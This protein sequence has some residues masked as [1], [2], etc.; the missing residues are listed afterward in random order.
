M[1]LSKLTFRYLLTLSL[2]VLYIYIYVCVCVLSQSTHLLYRTVLLQSL[3]L[4]RNGR[5]VPLFTSRICEYNEQNPMTHFMRVC[6]N[7]SICVQCSAVQCSFL[8]VC[9]YICVYVCAILFIDL[10]FFFLSH[11]K[12]QCLYVFCVHL[13]QYMS[14][15]SANHFL[16]FYSLGFSFILSGLNFLFFL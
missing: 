10:V 11:D 16:F 3:F 6:I 1:Y 8:Y 2:F 15:N 9:T 14:I 4:Y 5:S 12:E 7:I 13:V